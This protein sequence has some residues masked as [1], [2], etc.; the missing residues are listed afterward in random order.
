[1]KLIEVNHIT[2]DYGH[3]KGVFDLSFTVEKGEIIGILGPNGSGKTTTIRQLMG[4]IQSDQGTVQ[5][6]GLDCFQKAWLV[7]SQIGYLPGEM[8]M[9]ENMTGLAFI[10]WMA[11][12]KKMPSLT[13][14]KELIEFFELNPQVKIKKMSKGMK[15][16]VGLVVALMQDAPILI[17]D[18]PTSG[19]DPLMQKKFVTLMHQAKADGKTILMSSHIFEEVEHICD[20]VMMIKDGHLVADEKMA[21]LKRNQYKH[22]RIT[23]GSEE[24]AAALQKAFPQAV[25]AGCQVNFSYPGTPMPIIEKIKD[26]Q[27]EELLVSHQSL[28]ELFLSYYGGKKDD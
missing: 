26:M 8:A 12:M 27:V 22:Y 2:K 16:K 25:V 17:L 18:E 10:Q 9:M 21:K 3:Q 6:S 28:E 23:F 4:F 1:M 5:I 20:R 11:A 15:Q 14:A 13:K 7:Q 19:L 24:E